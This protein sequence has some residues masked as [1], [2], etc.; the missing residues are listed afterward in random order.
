MRHYPCHR[1]Q[2]PPALT[3]RLDD[4]AWADLPWTDDFVDI[5]GSARPEPPL[6]TR[7]KLGWDGDHLYVGAFLEDP[8]VQATITE[9][10]AVI[11][12]DPDFEIFIDPDGDTHHY[13][14]FE[15][16]ALGTIW[17]LYL[18]RPYHEGGPVHEGRNLPGLRSAVHVHGTLNDPSDIDRGWSVEV[19]IPFAD[20]APFAR[21]CACP[22][23]PGDR[24]R[25][26]F[27]RVH[28]HYEIEA[29]VYRKLP[30]EERDE[31]NWVWSP[32]G[33]IDM[34]RPEHWGIVEFR[35]SPR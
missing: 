30:K 3:G 27:S 24:W 35:D 20:L 10:N 4:L 2:R 14:E 21:G 22:P 5:E 29:G 28:W 18:E 32:Q 16:N 6:R 13:Y 26:N 19:A 7:A 12:H 15:I 34:H 25:V 33:V 1:V 8:H 23:R 9:K 11:F 31:E 17:E